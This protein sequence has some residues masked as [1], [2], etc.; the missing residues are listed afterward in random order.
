MNR[1]E[2]AVARLY[3][4]AKSVSE[5][6][7]SPYSGARVGARLGSGAAFGRHEVGFDSAVDSVTLQHSAH[8]R[9]GFASGALYAAEWIRGRQGLFEFS[10]ILEGDS[11]E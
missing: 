4:L 1:S 7:Y 3:E 6:A 9:D 5:N 2:R 10:G 8:G 11:E